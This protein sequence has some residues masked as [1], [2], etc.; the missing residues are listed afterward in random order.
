[1]ELVTL[2]TQTSS[3]TTIDGVTLIYGKTPSIKVA[4]RPT[5]IMLTKPIPSKWFHLRIHA[6][7]TGITSFSV[8]IDGVEVATAAPGTLSMQA[9]LQQVAAILGAKGTGKRPA[10]VVNYDDVILT[11]Q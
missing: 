7:V 5:A 3:D 11:A 6:V 9:G 1:V 10:I 8:F 2:R 4:S